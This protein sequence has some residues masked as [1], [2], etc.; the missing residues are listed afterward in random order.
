MVDVEKIKQEIEALKNLD[1]EDYCKEAVAK[2]YEEFEK[3][4][5][6]NIRDLEKALEIFEKYQIVEEEP[7]EEPVEENLEG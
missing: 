1:A 6:S 5:S 7:T 3:N 4:R 2:I